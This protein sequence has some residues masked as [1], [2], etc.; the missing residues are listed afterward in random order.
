MKYTK[1]VTVEDIVGRGPSVRK[2]VQADESYDELMDGR[3]EP[4]WMSGGE[5]EPLTTSLLDEHRRTSADG[6]S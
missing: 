6:Q 2:A 1:D 5:V 3:C 4:G